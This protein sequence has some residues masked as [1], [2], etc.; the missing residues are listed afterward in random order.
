MVSCFWAPWIFGSCLFQFWNPPPPP[1]VAHTRAWVGF[2][3][4]FP[5]VVKRCLFPVLWSALA[6]SQAD[7]VNQFPVFC[8][9]GSHWMSQV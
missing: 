7:Y 2:S 3:R 6:L 1:P 5:Q 8:F 4:D 9:D